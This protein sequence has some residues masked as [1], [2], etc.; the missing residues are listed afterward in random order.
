M[1]Q[2]EPSDDGS[3]PGPALFDL[4]GLTCQ[5][6]PSR[7]TERDS[8]P[9]GTS[10]AP[11]PA[12]ARAR[13]TGSRPAQTRSRLEPGNQA[14]RRRFK[15]CRVSNSHGLPPPCIDPSMM[16]ACV[17]AHAR[18][19]MCA[20]EAAA[21][22]ET[23]T[24]AAGT[25]SAPP[26]GGGVGVGGGGDRTRHRRGMCGATRPAGRMQGQPALLRMRPVR[27]RVEGGPGR[28]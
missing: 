9:R 13:L 20:S 1:I 3:V 19:R 5:H 25:A 2:F 28:G 10:G 12:P 24:P 7:A 23:M 15:C 16:Y 6:T 18:A 27:R 8:N 11:A 4:D 21:A 17:C 14:C 22:A 26:A